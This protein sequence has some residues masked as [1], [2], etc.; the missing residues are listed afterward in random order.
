MQEI[1]LQL[2]W[3]SY[4]HFVEKDT[5]ILENEDAK[6]LWDFSIQTERKLEHNKPDFVLLD[7]S[8]KVCF[9]L[10]VACS[11]DTRVIKKGK[12]RLNLIPT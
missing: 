3:K 10:D 1:W 9:V 8:K 11:F 2:L 6:I 5:R 4:E 7:K 12:K